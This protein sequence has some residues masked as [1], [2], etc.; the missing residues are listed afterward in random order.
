MIYV[1]IEIEISV[2]T[3]LKLENFK[4]NPVDLISLNPLLLKSTKILFTKFAT[5]IPRPFTGY[6]LS[7][8]RFI[9]I[10]SL[11]ILSPLRF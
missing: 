11:P 9:K 6:S 10:L 4:T 7:V 5:R 2:S 1:Y 3:S 8:H